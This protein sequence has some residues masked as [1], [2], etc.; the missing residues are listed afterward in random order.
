VEKKN[1]WD[2]GALVF[3]LS[4]KWAKS[5]ELIEFAARGR[6]FCAYAAGDNL[7][8][9]KVFTFD[10]ASSE[11]TE[12]G[13]LANVGERIS[14]GA[15][16]Q[17]FGGTMQ[18]LWRGEVVVELF[19]CGKEAGDFGIPRERLRITPGGIAPSHRESPIK[20]I[21]HVSDNIGGGARAI[22]KSEGGEGLRR[23]A[24]SLAAAIS[25]CGYRVAKKLAGGIGRCRHAVFPSA[26]NVA[27]KS[28]NAETQSTQRK[29]RGKRATA[30]RTIREGFG[31]GLDMRGSKK[32][33]TEVCAT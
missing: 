24:E 18:G 22:A 23:A 31:L 4:R 5:S 10:G 32:A 6:L 2:S 11:A 15:L 16:E 13:N 27:K 14:N 8:L 30:V 29:I 26:M 3:R 19:E 20:K 33:Q 28:L 1:R 7:R 12:H 17:T 21:A 9:E 25:D